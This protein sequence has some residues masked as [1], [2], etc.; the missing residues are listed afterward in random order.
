MTE[1]NFEVKITTDS[2]K[3]II[4]PGVEYAVS[5]S[6]EYFSCG[7][8][9]SYEEVIAYATGELDIDE[10]DS[11]FIGAVDRVNFSMEANDFYES[12]TG[13]YEDDLGEWSESWEESLFGGKKDL[14]AKVQE[15]LD[16]ICAMIHKEH[17]V[18]FYTVKDME[19]VVVGNITRGSADAERQPEQTI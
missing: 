19:C 14:R 6:E 7:G 10:D 15:K 1:K 11:F 12:L 5:T 2:D 8:L 9:K 16:E 17:P 18:S 3:F 4:K 13:Q